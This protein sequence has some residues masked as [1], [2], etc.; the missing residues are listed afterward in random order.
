MREVDWERDEKIRKEEG[1]GNC[2]R[3]GMKE[4]IRKKRETMER[5]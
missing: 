4:N 3:E 5:R 2:E 1:E